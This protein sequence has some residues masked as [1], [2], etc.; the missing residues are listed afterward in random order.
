MKAARKFTV[1]ASVPERLRPLLAIAYNLWWSWNPE[2]IALFQRLDY[3]LWAQLHHNP[4]DVLGVL[5]Q[6]RLQKLLEDDVFLSHMDRV[7]AELRRYMEQS[8]WYD[9]VHGE[10]LRSRI[11][12]FSAEFGIH[13]CLRLY[14]GGLGILSGDHLKSASDLGLPLTGIGLLYKHGYFSQ[15]LNREG[16]QQE[17][18][19]ANDFFHIPVSIEL[20]ED[21][22]PYMVEVE[23]PGRIVHAQIWR[24]QVGRAPLFLL[25]TRVESNS[26]ADRE[27]TSQLYGGDLEMRIKQEILL[28]IGGIRALDALGLT[29]TVCHMNEGH[30]AFLALERIRLLQRRHGLSFDEA[31]EVAAATNVF[32]THTPVPAGND[33]FPPDLVRTYFSRYAQELG[34][35]VNHL[36]DLG[37]QRPGDPEEPFCM[38]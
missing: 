29:P 4:I 16:W 26:P 2:A 23:Y 17:D 20:R 33:R 9:K 6:E 12:Y 3:D 38:T 32:T 25:D 36:I 8:T 34:I 35:P 5:P 10:M 27:I 1:M 22:T 21:G 11:A 13:E 15:Y 31:R 14:S 18:L 24:I 30:S 7:Y 19:P 37:R 28:G